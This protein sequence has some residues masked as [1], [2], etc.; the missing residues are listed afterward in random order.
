SSPKAAAASAGTT[1]VPSASEATGPAAPAGNA[2]QDQ[3]AANPTATPPQKTAPA[4]SSTAP[5]DVS[6]APNTAASATTSSTASKSD[7]SST[8]TK[9]KKHK[10]NPF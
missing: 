3:P 4:G 10:F 5:A 1:I 6:A 2:P 8:K 9:K 7:S